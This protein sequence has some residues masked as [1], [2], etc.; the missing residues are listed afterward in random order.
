VRRSEGGQ[1]DPRGRRITID[2]D[3]WRWYRGRPGWGAD[4]AAS[5]LG[6]SLALRD[7]QRARSPERQDATGDTGKGPSLTMPE[8]L[9]EKLTALLILIGLVAGAI[10]L[11]RL[12]G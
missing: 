4:D 1:T 7:A 9:G 8:S 6:E 12:P 5:R 11:T 3:L 10:A 2:R